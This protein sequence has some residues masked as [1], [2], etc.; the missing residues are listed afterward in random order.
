MDISNLSRSL[1][2]SVDEL[3]NGTIPEF[4]PDFPPNLVLVGQ[5]IGPIIKSPSFPLSS[6][7]YVIEHDPENITQVVHVVNNVSGSPDLRFSVFD[8][9]QQMIGE[10]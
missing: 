5:L 7:E 3:I 1:A 2:S 6:G 4:G 10:S 8:A 9:T